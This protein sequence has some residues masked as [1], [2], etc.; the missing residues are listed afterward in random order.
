MAWHS[1]EPRRSGAFRIEIVEKAQNQFKEQFKN[2]RENIKEKMASLTTP[3]NADGEKEKEK[4]KE[5][6]PILRP[7]DLFRLMSVKFP[8]F[9]LGLTSVKIRDE[10]CYLG[11]RKVISLSTSLFHITRILCY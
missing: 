7:G 4:E 6:D 5:F 9:E 8:E 3:R 2:I 11:L 10:F 1:N